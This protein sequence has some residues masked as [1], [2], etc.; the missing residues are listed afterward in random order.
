MKTQ[1]PPPPSA[2]WPPLAGVSAS[3]SA[4][5]SLF[6]A[7]WL[8]GTASL[9]WAQTP[10]PA[11]LGA[12]CA[13]CAV[14]PA[15]SADAAQQFTLKNGMRLIVKPDR[16]APTAVQMLWVRVGAMD[17]V[18][19]HSG[20]AHIL[21]HMMFKGS[22]RLGPGE[23]SRQV[24]ALGGQENAFTSMDYTGYY[25]QVPTQH[26][27]QVMRLEAERFAHNRWS[28]TEFSKE[29]EVI[30]EERRM[31]TEDNPR[32]LLGEQLYAASF[33]ASP[34]RRPIIGW[35]GDLDSTTAQD[36]RDFY[37]QW[38]TPS[39]AAIVVAGDVQ[40]DRV[41][42]WA[43]KYYGSLPVRAL[44]ERKPRA[45]PAQRG[46][47]RV[48]LKAPAEQ[49]YVALA[50][51]VPRIGRVQEMQESD[52]EALAL[53]VLSA[54]LSDYDGA[55]LERS[56][57]QGPQR[58]A[59]SA[60]SSA[61][62]LGRG[63]GLFLLSGVPAAGRS[64]QELEQALRA[65]ISRI[66]QEGVD[67]AELERVKTQWMAE[68]VY[69][70]DSLMAQAQSLGSYWVLGMP[71]DAEDRLVQHLRAVTAA[72]VQAVAAKYF[73][74]DA[75]TVATLLPQPRAA[76]ASAAPR[77]ASSRSSENKRVH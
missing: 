45:E 5:V 16:R 21:E 41:R 68:Q 1:T 20:L 77:A 63:P 6:L 35:M 8:S 60:G 65:Q 37:R 72:Q 9:A 59:D 67:N 36:V 64:S 23:F 10:S 11:A 31:R 54:V 30:K 19:G 24:A 53:L 17:E 33:V 71:P 12:V 25:Q 46:M 56:L 38:Y 49:G 22:Q 40:V 3:V 75:L 76:S 55:R 69:E 28:D 70:K 2:L 42:A 48:Q 44:P 52:R 18:D 29:I 27:E 43:E 13:V 62:V 15:V 47:R 58:V 4:T 51:H 66:A 14:A 50:F 26:L 34:Q 73:G 57:A 7:A 39:N 74:D 61:S 32:A